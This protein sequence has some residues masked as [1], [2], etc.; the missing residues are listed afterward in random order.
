VTRYPVTRNAEVVRHATHGS[1]GKR[2]AGTNRLV[3][4]GEPP[5]QLHLLFRRVEIES[6]SWPKTVRLARGRLDDGGV[7]QR[8][9][10]LYAWRSSRSFIA[11]SC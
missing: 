9:R 2:S 3:L 10:L 7:A 4:F 1:S 6:L 8:R 11:H 5:E